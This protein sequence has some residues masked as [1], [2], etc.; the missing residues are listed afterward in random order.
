MDNAFVL[1]VLAL[2][3]LKE[4][5]YKEAWIGDVPNPHWKSHGHKGCIIAS[6]KRKKDGWP[7]IWSEGKHLGRHGCANGL[8]NADQAFKENARLMEPGHYKFNDGR[9]EKVD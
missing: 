7:A 9:W 2:D 8:A 6:P 5:G 3:D 4:L 1:T